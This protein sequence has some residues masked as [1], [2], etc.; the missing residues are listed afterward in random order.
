DTHTADG[1]KVAREHRGA[2]PMVVLET[3]LPIKFAATIEEALGH[4]PERPVKFDGIEALPRRVRVLP[5]DA[6]RVKALIAEECD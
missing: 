5:A 3:A 4:P 2:E 1:V 6:A